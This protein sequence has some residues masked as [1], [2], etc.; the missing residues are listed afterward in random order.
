MNC[1]H[2]GGKT[3]TLSTRHEPTENVLK[4]RRQC[5]NCGQRF[6]TVEAIVPERAKPLATPRPERVSAKA[7]ARP[8][9]RRERTW[10]GDDDG[11]VAEVWGST[12][13]RLNSLSDLDYL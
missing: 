6:A 1:T 5:K 3:E 7:P 2:C 12:P 9:V 10:R 8:K 13:S 11:L 4:R